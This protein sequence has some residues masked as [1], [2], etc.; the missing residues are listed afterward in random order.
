MGVQ[1]GLT[2]SAGG[3]GP[4]FS[5]FYW[6]QTHLDG[7]GWGGARGRYQGGKGGVGESGVGDG[8]VACQE[9]GGVELTC[10]PHWA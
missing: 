8:A 4:S 10:L 7:L 9:L 6:N 2:R 5:G 1:G 3:L